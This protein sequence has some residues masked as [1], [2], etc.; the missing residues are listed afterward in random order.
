VLKGTATSESYVTY[1]LYEIRRDPDFAAYVQSYFASIGSYGFGIPDT[2]SP[3]GL[4]Q[5]L[6]LEVSPGEPIA[7][8]VLDVVYDRG[9]GHQW[10]T[11]RSLDRSAGAELYRPPWR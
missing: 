5:A 1:A 8:A 4:E 9:R 11:A 6:S 10:M 2:T 7:K 3:E